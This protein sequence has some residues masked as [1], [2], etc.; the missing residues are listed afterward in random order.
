MN[1]QAAIRRAVPVIAQHGSSD[2]VILLSWLLRAGLPRALAIRAVW[3]IPLAFGRELLGSMGVVLSDT[4]VR[5]TE[6]GGMG[7]E[8]ELAG[9]EVFREAVK[10]APVLAQEL[11]KDVFTAV[12]LQSSEMDAVNQALNAGISA[13]GLV[14][15]SPVIIWPEHLASGATEK[16]PWW[17][18]WG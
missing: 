15:S 18:V 7:D 11:G 14:A 10:L 1:V 13:E 4:Y 17:K 8:R 12:A 3:F 2:P 6:A 5:M 16:R 9:E